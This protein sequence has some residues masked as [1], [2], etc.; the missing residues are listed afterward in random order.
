MKRPTVAWILGLFGLA[1][2]ACCREFLNAFPGSYVWSE[3]MINYQG[4]YV[5]R[6][7][8]GE[9]SYQLRNL[10]PPPY[11]FCL[12]I[13]ASTFAFL[14]FLH[15]FFHRQTDWAVV[16]FLL[17]PLSLFFP[18]NDTAAFGRKDILILCAFAFAFWVRKRISS[19]NV[20][21]ALL[22]AVYLLTG[23]VTEAAIFF[24]PLAFAVLMIESPPR[25]GVGSR[26]QWIS[27]AFFIAFFAAFPLA[28]HRIS[29]PGLLK[30]V[31]SWQELYPGA[32]PGLG[33][34]SFLTRSLPEGI[35]IVLS[36]TFANWQTSAGYLLAAALGS[37]PF[38]LLFA[39]RSLVRLSPLTRAGIFSA[40][41]FMGGIF[42][43][44]ADW[45]RNLYLVNI[46][47]FL[48]FWFITEPKAEVGRLW[49]KPRTAL[50][51][52]LWW[53]GTA[54]YSVSW[55]VDHIAW[56]GLPI[57]ILYTYVLSLCF[58]LAQNIF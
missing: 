30:M 15:R 45:G 9:T 35:Q 17:S 23:L 21:I 37:L 33:A 29:M 43:V 32:F 8:L 27:G 36:G 38:V 20:Q 28:F 31:S 16:I 44:A 19:L 5:R 24:F 54:C 55:S 51:T 34:Q 7:L 11:F 4:G 18:I 3:L 10:V 57:R 47:C 48:L 58:R 1:Y 14:F 52:T 46:H 39:T 13:L 49:D 2:L 22:M 12:V 42:L 53:A 56:A 26:L 41:L 25:K 6:G 40:L 50:G